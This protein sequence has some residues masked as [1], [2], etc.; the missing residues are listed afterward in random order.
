[1]AYLGI[2]VVVSA[3][4]IAV[5]VWRQRAHTPR[6]VDASID[7][8]ARARSALAPEAHPHVEPPPSGTDRRDPG[9][10]HVVRIPRPSDDR[11]RT[12]GRSE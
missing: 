2:A 7:R 3:V 11:G 5:L 9:Y 8:F 10:R 4:G 12:S 6:S 1:M